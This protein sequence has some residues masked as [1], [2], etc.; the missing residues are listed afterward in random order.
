MQSIGENVATLT[1]LTEE[2]TRLEGRVDDL[3]DIGLKELFLKHRGGNAMDYIV[4][5]EIYK[6]LEKVADRFDDV[7]NEINSI[8]IEQVEG[9]GLRRGCFPWFSNPDRIDYRCAPFD[10]LNGLH[11]AAN[12]I[13]TIVSTRVLRP[14]YAVAWA[15]FFNFIAFTVFGLHVAQTIGTGIIE[16]SVIDAAGDLRST[17][18]CDCVEPDHMGRRHPIEQLARADWRNAG[19]WHRQSR[20]FSGCLEWIVQN[21]VGHRA[22]AVRGLFARSGF[23]CHVVGSGA[24][25]TIRRRS[26]L[27]DFAI[28]VSLTVFAG[29]R[30]Q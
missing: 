25:H 9:L 20:D 3:H 18:R 8:V 16:P 14:Q 11:D 21:I 6:H 28:C 12:S 15:A 10:F 19:G 2:V 29:P 27:P 30:R 24:L 13:A 5:D 17:D 23:D 22:L 26:C 1:A 4:G 7:A